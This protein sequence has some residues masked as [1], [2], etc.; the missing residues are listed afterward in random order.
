MLL[1]IQSGNDVCFYLDL[2]RF[3]MYCI[4]RMFF[5]IFPEMLNKGSEMRNHG[6]TLQA[7]MQII[8][9]VLYY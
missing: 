9:L 3:G 2:S 1:R 7:L 4:V 8:E 6:Y 5:L